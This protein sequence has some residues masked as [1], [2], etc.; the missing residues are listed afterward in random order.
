MQARC[1]SLEARRTALSSVLSALQQRATHIAVQCGDITLT[2]AQ[3]EEHSRRLALELRALGAKQEDRI[4]LC[5]GRRAELIV[6]MLAIWRAGAAYV[7]LDPSYPNARLQEIAEDAGLTAIVSD[8]ATTSH[9][10]GTRTMWIDIDAPPTTVDGLLPETSPTQAAYIL[11]TSGTTG[12]PKGVVI[13]QQHVFAL[14][15]AFVTRFALTA[16]DRVLQFA[17]VNFDVSVEEIFATLA[18]GA[19]VV[20]RTDSMLTSLST[21]EQCLRDWRISLADLPTVFW[22]EWLNHIVETQSNLPPDLR[23]ILIGGERTTPEHVAKWRALKR[24]RPRLFNAYGPTETT[25]TATAY[26]LTPGVHSEP[27]HAEVPIGYPLPHYRCYILNDQQAPVASGEQGE[28][29]I[30]G[31]AVARGYL[32]RPERTSDCF[33]A[34]PFVPDANA[35]MYRTG[36]RVRELP[37]GS[38]EF[39]GR[40]DTQVKIRGFRI[41]LGEIERRLQNH[42][43][44]QDAVV[45]VR[46]NTPGDRRLISYVIPLPNAD[47][48]PDLLRATLAEQLPSYMVPTTVLFVGAFPVKPNGKLDIDALPTVSIPTPTSEF[49]PPV[50]PTEIFLTSLWRE[51][52]GI[53]RVGR[54]D[55]LFDLGAH[56]LT[57]LRAL[58]R[59]RNELGVEVSL[60]TLLDHP[61]PA[62]IAPLLRT[63]ATQ[64]PDIE[65]VEWSRKANLV[66]TQWSS[67]AWRRWAHDV[68]GIRNM[69]IP[70]CMDIWLHGQLDPDTVERALRRLVARHE[71]LRIPVPRIRGVANAW[72]VKRFMG[73]LLRSFW[74]SRRLIP[75]LAKKVFGVSGSNQS[76]DVP[77]LNMLP[78]T[79]LTLEHKAFPQTATTNR[80][81]LITHL[82]KERQKTVF[83]EDSLPIRAI[84]WRTT[85]DT[86]LLSLIIDH[87]VT[88]GGSEPAIFDDFVKCYRIEANTANEPVDP[89]RV[90]F[91]DF[92]Y[93]TH[94]HEALLREL[95][96]DYLQRSFG[97]NRGILKLPFWRSAQ[98]SSTF[99]LEID[100]VQRAI[101]PDVLGRLTDIAK[102]T[103]TTV[104]MLYLSALAVTLMRLLRTNAVQIQGSLANRSLPVLTD[105]IGC[106][107]RPAHWN[108]SLT[109]DATWR[110]LFLTTADAVLDSLQHQNYSMNQQVELE[111]TTLNNTREYFRPMFDWPRV[112]FDF[113]PCIPPKTILPGLEARSELLPAPDSFGDLTVR[114]VDQGENR[115]VLLVGFSTDRWEYEG[116]MDMT[117]LLLSLLDSLSMES[118]DRLVTYE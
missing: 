105:M 88:D 60:K 50:G 12:R 84:L 1:H 49:V 2:Y 11:Y 89:P 71:P 63:T 36:D 14:V 17:S 92:L 28:L 104:S 77:H 95:H 115:H 76:T 4:G 78:A 5:M 87:I 70:V 33:L 80:H 54:H 31:D 20:M 90:Q 111:G 96:G 23:M 13:E 45:I 25:V 48:T 3:I 94:R 67:V 46:E 52:L 10:D 116:V 44:I 64:L 107:V 103:R 18:T 29:Y 101:T 108:I 86:H 72:I 75:W 19:T 30:G 47:V 73:L 113:M 6:G 26:E 58:T 41:E 68:V 69:E 22:H 7:P 42:N 106:L 81:A 85:S 65:S 110:T 56:S 21:F 8:A 98:P 99:Q 102:E 117:A 53:E 82:N 37:N 74:C 83:G 34:N 55:S 38:L 93:W 79:L 59:I 57:A 114:I 15:D 100:F 32:N 112:Y 109:P 39:L 97:D 40:I 62:A 43:G 27:D 118:L 66:F 9:F 61:T 91:S 16:E 51:L 24:T 35:R